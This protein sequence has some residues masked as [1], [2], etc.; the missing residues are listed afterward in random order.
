M[1]LKKKKRI[2]PKHATYRHHL[3]DEEGSCSYKL[4][5]NDPATPNMPPNHIAILYL[6]TASLIQ[7]GIM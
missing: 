3:Q 4:N 1:D 6:L 7:Q 5:K 2:S